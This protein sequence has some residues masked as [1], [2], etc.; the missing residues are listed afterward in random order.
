MRPFEFEIQTHWGRISA[1][2]NSLGSVDPRV[3]DNRSLRRRTP[4]R[5]AKFSWRPDIESNFL[6]PMV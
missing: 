1:P 3:I 6:P 2:L 4:A 5:R